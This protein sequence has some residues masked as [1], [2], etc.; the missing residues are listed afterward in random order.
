MSEK[1][2]YVITQDTTSIFGKIDKKTLTDSQ[3]NRA[4][5]QYFRSLESTLAQIFEPDIDVTSY[6]EAE[7]EEKLQE[8]IIPIL[9]QDE[10]SVCICLDRFLLGGLEETDKYR[11]RIFRF[12]MCRAV[13]GEKV[14]RQGSEPLKDQIVRLNKQ[15]GKRKAI[16]V[17]D[18]LF[19]GGTVKE[20]LR[21]ATEGNVDFSINKVI[22]FIGNRDVRLDE[23]VSSEIIEP[24]DNLFDWIDI[25]DFSPLAGKRYS[26][27]QSNGVTS[28]IPYLFPWSD[29]ASASL[30]LSP[31]FFDVSLK[32]ISSFKN[33]V[34]AFEK[35]TSSPLTFRDLVRAGFPLPTNALKTIPVSINDKITDYLDYC[36]DLI[37]YERDRKVF[38]FDMDGTVYQLDGIN[39]GFK[40]S[41]LESVVKLNAK[42]FI[43]AKEE[44]DETTA[45]TILE[46]ATKDEVGISR[47]LS[48]KYG[49]SR[50][51]Y[52]DFVW[53]INPEGIVRNFNVALRLIRKLKNN[54]QRKLIL[55]T[56]A[57]QIWA[58]N[59]MDFLGIMEDFE[60]IYTG[61]QFDKKERIFTMLAARYKPKNITSIGDQER[62]DIKPARDLGMNTL[63]ITG[64]N[65]LDRVTI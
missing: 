10:N 37:Q 6:Y 35:S 65:D 27:S 33:L 59:V 21:L 7:I 8:R 17:D 54:P 53:N 58:N 11:S 18:G 20:F 9:D 40:G 22:G 45:Q 57:P 1:S 30:N 36:V 14:P 29:G 41:T 61:E 46:Q 47:F 13:N 23:R 26:A 42:G 56:S 51:D 4:V 12:G 5:Q 62:T 15:I 25:R 24:I 64:P 43:K 52:F 34:I 16:L 49:I 39:N 44:C 63:L 19:S 60:A 50:K 3:F 28:S 32:A 38:V 48:E 2:R 31:Q 55:L